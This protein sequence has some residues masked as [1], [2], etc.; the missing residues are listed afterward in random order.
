MTTWRRI[1]DQREIETTLLNRNIK[2][3]QQANSTPFANGKLLKTFGYRGVNQASSD[4]I[5][6]NKLPDELE[7]EDEFVKLFIN[8]L[9][10]GKINSIDQ[11]ISFEEFKQTIDKWNESTTMSPSRRHLGHYKLISKLQINDENNQQVNMSENILRTIYNIMMS[12]I[13]LGEPIDRWKKITTCMIEKTV[14][15]AKIN[16]LRVIHIFE[17]D[18][19]LI[20]KCMWARKAVWESHKKNLLN[21]SQAGSRPGG[22]A[23]EVAVQK[24]MKYT[25]AKLTRTPLATIDNGAKSCFD[26]ILCNI[27]MLVSQYYGVPIDYCK[28]QS[29]TLQNT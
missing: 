27:A 5:E 15:V 26:R 13:K 17:A 4:L 6:N 23:I 25:Y 21:V 11:D 28:L 2:H 18:Y 20:L 14:G 10:E 29:T 8:K 7:A 19:N 9:S 16:K 3:F 12:A 1:T 22:R 24:E